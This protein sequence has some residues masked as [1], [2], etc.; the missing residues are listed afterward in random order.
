MVNIPTGSGKGSSLSGLRKALCVT[1]KSGRKKKQR[2]LA[3]VANNI[4]L[5]IHLV[6]FIARSLWYICAFS[7]EI[8]VNY[9]CTVPTTCS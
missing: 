7:T 1:T 9:L 6:K 5:I 2:F 4:K 8:L 3:T